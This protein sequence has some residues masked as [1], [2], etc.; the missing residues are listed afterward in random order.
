MSSG[1]DGQPILAGAIGELSRIKQACV[2][3]GRLQD[4]IGLKNAFARGPIRQHGENHGR[5]N[6]AAT[7]HRLA[8]KLARHTTVRTSA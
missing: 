2:D 4:G 7:D 5:R 6:A 3:V 8:A 1:C